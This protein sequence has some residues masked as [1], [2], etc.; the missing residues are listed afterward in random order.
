M[1]LLG[2]CYYHGECGFC[3]IVS[4]AI[5]WWEKAADKNSAKALTE[6]GNVH[7]LGLGGLPK[8]LQLAYSYYNK[9]LTYG[10]NVM[11]VIAAVGPEW[12]QP[13]LATKILEDQSRAAEY[14][15]ASAIDVKNLDQV[16]LLAKLLNIVGIEKVSLEDS[17]SVAYIGASKQDQ[18]KE[19]LALR[20]ADKEKSFPFLETLAHRYQFTPAK[21]ELAISYQNGW[22]IL[23]DQEKTRILLAEVENDKDANLLDR[24]RACDG[25]AKLYDD[26][27]WDGA[28]RYRD[29]ADEFRT[30]A[31]KA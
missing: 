28:Q 5:Q 26:L 25:L 18:L 1:F 23:K 27:I 11:T 7:R 6:M 3:E 8:N 21:I 29:K 13:D 20:D 19:A 30:L 15:T 31:A 2:K 22:G 12:G 14:L 9:A 10:A 4:Q 17:E 24:A 16:Q